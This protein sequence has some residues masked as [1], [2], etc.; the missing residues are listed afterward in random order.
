MLWIV[1]IR[2]AMALLQSS[3]LVLMPPKLKNAEIDEKLRKLRAYVITYQEDLSARR[4]TTLGKTLQQDK[5]KEEESHYQFVHRANKQRLLSQDQEAHLQET[6]ALLRPANLVATATSSSSSSAAPV[7]VSD[8]AQAVHDSASPKRRKTNPVSSDISGNEVAR[9]KFKRKSS[10][11]TCIESGAI[12]PTRR[13]RKRKTNKHPESFQ[14]TLT[15]NHWA[16]MH[17]F[18]TWLSTPEAKNIRQEEVHKDT[19]AVQHL[20][21]YP[22][23]RNLLA[24]AGEHFGV[25]RLGS[26]SVVLW[27]HRC[28]E[29]ALQRFRWWKKGGFLKLFQQES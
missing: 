4:N 29:A 17:E 22:P 9:S 28:V 19:Q 16:E 8:E 3:P 26:Q 1:I 14:E 13:T 5:S 12:P 20:L 10:E 25:K 21:I 27:H 2:N 15:G 7:P 23:F 24:T 6:F 18:N 11:G